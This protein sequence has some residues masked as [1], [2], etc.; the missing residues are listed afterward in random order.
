M[1]S[2]YLAA[3]LYVNLSRLLPFRNICDAAIYSTLHFRNTIWR[4][5][6]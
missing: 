5:F 3:A 2:L 6:A 1:P 4:R